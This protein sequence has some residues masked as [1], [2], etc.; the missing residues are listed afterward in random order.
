MLPC[1][2]ILII[3]DDQDDIY[4]LVD[5]LFQTGVEKVHYVYST[6]E[7]S[8]YLEEICPECTPRVI[9]S[10]LLLPMI[11]GPDFLQDLKSKERY[12]NIKMI[13]LS[14]VR[15]ERRV[16]DLLQRNDF[17]FFEKPYSFQGYLDI[18][19]NIKKQLIA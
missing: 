11:N 8:K 4:T 2:E 14:S 17:D 10:D 7:A 19:S 1:N 6:S 9:V 13:V 18:A 5:A 3:D 16:E 15:P 12:K